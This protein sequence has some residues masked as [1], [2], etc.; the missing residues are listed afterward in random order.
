MGLKQMEVLQQTLFGDVAT[1]P[2]CCA[3][4]FK[5]AVPLTNDAMPSAWVSGCERLGVNLGLRCGGWL[6]FAVVLQRGK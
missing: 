2:Y 1:L 4:P 5:S 6:C 3:W